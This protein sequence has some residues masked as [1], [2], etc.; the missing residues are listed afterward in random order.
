MKLLKSQVKLQI[1]DELTQAA[2][3]VFDPDQ[4]ETSLMKIVQSN[5][6]TALPGDI[7]LFTYDGEA[8]LRKVLIVKTNTA[9]S[10][11]FTSPQGNRLLCCFELEQQLGTLT[12]VFD[13]LY[14]SDEFASYERYKGGLDLFFGRSKYKTFSVTKINNFYEVQVSKAKLTEKRLR[15]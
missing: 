7:A 11:K 5:Y 8:V 4:E 3:D 12:S 10:G 13:K 14:K 9:K 15:K 1:P 2:T 6:S